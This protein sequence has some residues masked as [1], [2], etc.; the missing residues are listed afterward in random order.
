M[1]QILRLTRDLTRRRNFRITI[2]V[3]RHSD[4]MSREQNILYWKN[5]GISPRYRLFLPSRLRPSLL[6]LNQSFCSSLCFL[7]CQPL[8]PN[9]NFLSTMSCKAPALI[10]FVRHCPQHRQREIIRQNRLDGAHLSAVQE[11]PSPRRQNRLCSTPDTDHCCK[12]RLCTDPRSSHRGSR[13]T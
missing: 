9:S 3:T 12:T 5:V 11:D 4:R 2:C 1:P 7:L 6:D 13:H 8:V 10:A